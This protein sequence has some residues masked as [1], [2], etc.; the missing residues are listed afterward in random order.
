MWKT[1]FKNFEGYD[2]PKQTTL[3]QIL[4]RLSSILLGPFLN[5][6]SHIQQKIYFKSFKS[7]KIQVFSYPESIRFKVWQEKQQKQNY[8]C[9][10]NFKNRENQSSKNNTRISE[11]IFQICEILRA[12]N[13]FILLP[14]K[15]VDKRSQRRI[16]V[17]FV[18]L[19]LQLFP[20]KL[21]R[22]FSE[23]LLLISI[24]HLKLQTSI[25]IASPILFHNLQKYYSYEIK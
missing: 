17:N 22:T 5:D 7:L 15:S 23:M 20:T 3:L 6:L 11:K 14:Q 16:L 8:Q 18:F 1:A 24:S 2:L 21:S 4:W 25:K 9:S 19:R 13:N 10:W 12:A